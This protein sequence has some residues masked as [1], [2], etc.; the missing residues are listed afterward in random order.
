MKFVNEIAAVTQACRRNTRPLGQHHTARPH[1]GNE[2]GTSA[3]PVHARFSSALQ[4]TQ[5]LAQRYHPAANLFNTRKNNVQSC[6]G[7]VQR[8]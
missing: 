5:L 4:P 6:D 8:P 2:S 3:E 1:G 7:R